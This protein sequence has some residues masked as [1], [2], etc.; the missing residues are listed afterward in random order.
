MSVIWN[1][2]AINDYSRTFGQ[3]LFGIRLVNPPLF[4]CQHSV[5]YKFGA[6]DI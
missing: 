3:W 6:K 5:E 2:S 4:D 1:I